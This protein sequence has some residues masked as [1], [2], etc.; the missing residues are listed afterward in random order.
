M[1]AIFTIGVSASGKTTWAKSLVESNPD[2]VI[3][4]RDDIRTMLMGGKL[5]WSK[6]DW[7]REDEVSRIQWNW[8]LDAKAHCL[9]VIIADT[10]LPSVKN[11]KVV[12]SHAEKL[13]E[14]MQRFGFQ[15][16]WKEFDVTLE[17]AIER[18]K[19]REGSVGEDVIRRQYKSWM[20][21]KGMGE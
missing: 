6:W 3:I 19:K 10:N 13:A 14:K 12:F 21:Y 8:I 17:E 15:I 18:D 16:S 5:D 1:Q 4:C 11:G 2:W 9:N 20:A 7:R